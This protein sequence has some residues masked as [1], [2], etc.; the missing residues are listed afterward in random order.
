MY[1]KQDMRFHG[2][3]KPGDTL[4]AEVT[5]SAVRPEKAL[6]N[7]HTIARVGGR[8]VCEGEALVMA[9]QFTL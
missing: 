2:R 6:V 3:V 4:R 5:I 9:R 7:L 8:P 1:L